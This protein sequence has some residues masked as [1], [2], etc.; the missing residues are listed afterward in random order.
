MKEQV[1]AEAPHRDGSATLRFVILQRSV[2]HAVTLTR[3]RAPLSQQIL[4]WGVVLGIFLAAFACWGVVILA[5][6]TVYRL[7]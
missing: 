4:G 7:L 3:E 2:S 6:L 5:G 1:G